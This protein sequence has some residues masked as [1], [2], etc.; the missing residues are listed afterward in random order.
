MRQSMK[1]AGLLLGGSI[2]SSS[3]ACAGETIA[4][5]TLIANEISLSYDFGGTPVTIEKAA[6]ASFLVDRVVD[7]SLEPVDAAARVYGQPGDANTRMVFALR[8]EGNDRSGYALDI[9]SSGDL[10]LT[11]GLSG[12]PG[13]FRVFL[14]GSQAPEPSDLL[15][16]DPSRDG[17]LL[18]LSPGEARYIVIDIEIPVTASNGQIEQISVDAIAYDPGPGAPYLEE[19]GNGLS[20]IDTIFGDPGEDGRESSSELLEVLASLLGIQKTMVV[21]SETRPAGFDCASDAAVPGATAAVA[22]ACLEWTLTV[23]NAASAPVGARNIVLSDPLPDTLS[24]V[25]AEKGGFD[26]VSELSGIVTGTLASL[27]PGA[28]ASF[29][30]RTILGDL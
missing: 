5:G 29:T 15:A 30:I 21:I 1:I 27:A 11:A 4:P 24:F 16:I 26:V 12:G 2:F 19:R 8:N 7:F 28:S 14:S 6:T 23:T 18:E 17:I 3:P 25:G 10:A 13:S 9:T 20:G 22:G